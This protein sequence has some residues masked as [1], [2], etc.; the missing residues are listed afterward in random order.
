MPPRPAPRGR[1]PRRSRPRRPRPPPCP[2]PPRPAGPR[3]RPLRPAPRTVP[4]VLRRAPAPAPS[5]PPGSAPP[6][7]ARTAVRPARSHL[8]PVS[9][10]PVPLVAVRCLQ[11]GAEPAG[12]GETRRS[13]DR[14][15]LDKRAVL[16]QSE[17]VNRPELADFLRRSRARLNPSDVGLAP[18]TR[19]RTP[20][21]RREEVAA[22][23]G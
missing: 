22:L 6:T 18:G 3:A 10:S 19:R 7:S 14:Q 23:A 8:S 21:L 11:R 16:P 17:E 13:G 2:A 15:S 9:A 20:G 5:P 1:T 12:A 4:P